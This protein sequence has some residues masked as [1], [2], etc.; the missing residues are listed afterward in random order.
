VLATEGLFDYANAWQQGYPAVA[1]MHSTLTRRQADILRDFALPTY[2]FYD[3]DEA[4]RKGVKEAGRLLYRY[5][6]VM[7]VRYPEIWIENADEP[8]GGHWVKDPG[9]LVELDFKTMVE[10]ARLWTP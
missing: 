5:T 10:D 4:G 8:D 1:V 3:A 2:L 7:K 9:E 6:S